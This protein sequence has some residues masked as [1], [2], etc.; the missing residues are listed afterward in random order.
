MTPTMT[1]V[2][3]QKANDTTMTNLQFIK[4]L[5]EL[6]LGVASYGTAFVLGIGRRQLQRFCSGDVEVS[7]PVER[8]LNMYRKHG[9]PRELR[10]PTSGFG[11]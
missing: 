6:G 5:D 4:A 11:S 7:K 2:G 9:I 8:L 3:L 10:H 1:K